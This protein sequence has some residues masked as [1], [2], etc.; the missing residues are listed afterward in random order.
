[1]IAFL[2][3]LV[4]AAS[5]SVL[6]ASAESAPSGDVQLVVDGAGECCAEVPDLV[7]C[8]GNHRCVVLGVS[9]CGAGGVGGGWLSGSCG[10]DGEEGVG[11]HGEGGP[12]VPGGPGADL[13]FVQAGAA[14]ACLE[15][16]LDPPAGP[17]HPHQRCEWGCR[18]EAWTAYFDSESRSDAITAVGGRC[19]VAGFTGVVLT[20]S[21]SQFD[22][23][24]DF[25]SC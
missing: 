25:S 3:R 12:A 14:L 4:V 13:V 24:R 17:G 20:D 22:H 18:D 5:G 9:G 6:V 23:K 11:E 19:T 7:A 8:K 15:V 1:V 21:Q 16:L 10:G 2:S